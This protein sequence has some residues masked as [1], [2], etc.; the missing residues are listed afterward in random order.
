M[1]RVSSQIG[2]QLA[3]VYTYRYL[4]NDESSVEEVGAECH[5]QSINESYSPCQNKTLATTLGYAH[6]T[7][8]T[9]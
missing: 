4:S 1:N 5:F 6:T 7:E 3:D 8:Q 2:P 9:G